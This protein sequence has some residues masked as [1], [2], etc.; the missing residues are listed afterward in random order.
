MLFAYILYIIIKYLHF[1]KTIKALFYT[2]T[3]KNKGVFSST[4]N[5][6]EKDKLTNK[7]SICVDKKNKNEYKTNE[8]VISSNNIQK[9]I[10]QRTNI[11]YFPYQSTNTYKVDNSFDNL[12][13]LQCHNYEYL[14]IMEGIYKHHCS[15]QNSNSLIKY[16]P[17]FNNDYYFVYFLEKNIKLIKTIFIQYYH[18]GYIK[19]PILFQTKIIPIR[20]ANHFIDLFTQYCNFPRYDVFWNLLIKKEVENFLY[21]PQFR[22]SYDYKYNKYIYSLFTINSNYYHNNYYICNNYDK[23]YHIKRYYKM[24]RK[25]KITR[26]EPSQTFFKKNINKIFNR[27]FIHNI[28][29]RY[30]IDITQSKF[31]KFNKKQFKK[32]DQKYKFYLYNEHNNF[33]MK[34]IKSQWIYKIIKHKKINKKNSLSSIKQE[35]KNI[36]GYNTTHTNLI[37]T[38]IL[39]I[40]KIN[41]KNKPCQLRIFLLK[42]Y[43][44]NNTFNISQFF[45]YWYEKSQNLSNIIID[46]SHIT[47][48]SKY[49][50]LLF[51]DILFCFFIGNL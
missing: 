1:F 17:F 28:Y 10:D 23:I 11:T 38:H 37:F 8:K 27:N 26:K 15:F 44:E 14:K 35:K 43:I 50:H 2:F 45:K 39:N 46:T 9:N 4:N 6:I 29:Y 34:K 51:T 33:Q 3:K 16:L 22:K 32:D 12:K 20:T 49:I 36:Y 13:D 5:N 48:N 21:L 31:F 18:K 40:I 25:H 42:S 47:L 24:K 41:F 30:R 7:S 19:K